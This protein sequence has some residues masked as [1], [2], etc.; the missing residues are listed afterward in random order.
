M[1]LIIIDP[2][3]AAAL[4]GL[5]SAPIAAL[6]TYRRS[7][8]KEENDALESVS[9]SSVD[10]VDTVSKALHALHHELNA[11]RAQIEI[12]SE[13]NA[14]LQDSIESLRRRNDDLHERN[15]KLTDE[16]ARLRKA[17]ER[18]IKDQDDSFSRLESR[19]ENG[20]GSYH[21]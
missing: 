4:I 16:V 1:E 20:N 2:T 15:K 21:R 17:V 13:E 10:A 9:R 11:A 19:L 8:R 7:R 18:A 14:L 5:A 3:V 12:L 6:V